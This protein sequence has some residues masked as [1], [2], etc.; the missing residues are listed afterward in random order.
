VRHEAPFS[1][2]RRRLAIPSFLFLRL[3][4]T[5]FLL[6]RA[7]VDSTRA[8][9]LLFALRP[10]RPT[11][12]FFTVFVVRDVLLLYHIVTFTVFV[13]RGVLLLYHIVVFKNRITTYL[14]YLNI[15]VPNFCAFLLMTTLARLQ[16]TWTPEHTVCTT[17]RFRR[18]LT[19]FFDDYFLNNLGVVMIHWHPLGTSNNRCSLR[20]TTTRI[21]RATRTTSIRR[22]T[23]GCWC[24][25]CC[26]RYFN[27]LCRPTSLFLFILI[28]GSITRY[29][30]PRATICFF[31]L[32]LSIFFTYRSSSGIS[33]SSS[34]INSS[35]GISSSSRGISSSI[36]S[37]STVHNRFL[38]I[39]CHNGGNIVIIY[40]LIIFCGFFT[41]LTLTLL[42][43]GIRIVFLLVG[44]F[45][46]RTWG[47][48]PTATARTSRCVSTLHYGAFLFP[49]LLH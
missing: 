34:G 10:C 49:V 46:F 14:N 8:L 48:T 11:S 2:F 29:P 15:V 23:C 36:S 33:S 35:S 25:G 3:R 18:L 13:I 16:G 47:A 38:F 9:T 39:R 21:R 45:C 22:T 26:A 4:V 27:F 1:F 37:T 7:L 17:Y 42:Q 5:V 40:T 12:T 41:N 24:S 43:N 28:T 31:V 30:R 44:Y 32:L 6:A 20:R 19:I